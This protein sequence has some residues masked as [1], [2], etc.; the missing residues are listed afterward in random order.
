VKTINNSTHNQPKEN[1]K[2]KTKFSTQKSTHLCHHFNHNATN[3]FLLD[4][5]K[6]Q[7]SKKE[8]ENQTRKI[9]CKIEESFLFSVNLLLPAVCFFCKPLL[10]LSLSGFSPHLFLLDLENTWVPFPWKPRKGMLLQLVDDLLIVASL[11]R[12]GQ[13]KANMNS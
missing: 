11:A 9:S 7:L 1:T 2:N 10:S 4:T 5:V 13:V 12:D 6:I 8:K 3:L